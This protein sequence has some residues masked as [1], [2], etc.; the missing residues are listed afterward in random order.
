[1]K[2]NFTEFIFGIQ[3]PKIF[4]FKFYGRKKNKTFSYR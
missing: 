4:E 1:M 3:K 2:N